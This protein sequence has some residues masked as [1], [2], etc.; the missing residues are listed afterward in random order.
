MPRVALPALLLLATLC[1][2]SLPAAAQRGSAEDWSRCRRAIAATE[3]GSG[4]PPGLLGAIA[5]VESGQ[6]NPL[7]GAPTPWPWSYNAAGESHTASTKATAIAEVSALLARGV[8]SIDVGCMQVNLMHHPTA[9]ANLEEAFDPQANLRY[10]ARFLRE[11]RARTGDWGQAIARYHSG[12]EARGAAYSSRVALARMGAAWG[13]GGGVPLPPRVVQNICAPGLTPMLLL[14]GAREARRFMTPEARRASRAVP[15]P[16][17][18]NRP[19]LVCLRTT[20][21]R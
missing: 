12:E 11:L 19:R 15:V 10:A 18:S 17:A 13:R 16:P 6:R 3:P 4:V 14:G 5:L 8:R 1:L 7:T 21:R 2:L 20:A 9:F